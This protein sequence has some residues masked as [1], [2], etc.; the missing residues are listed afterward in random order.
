MSYDYG[1]IGKE[2]VKREGLSVAVLVEIYWC[3]AWTGHSVKLGI[4]ANCIVLCEFAAG[5]DIHSL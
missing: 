4:A 3:M 2:V 1:P 5:S